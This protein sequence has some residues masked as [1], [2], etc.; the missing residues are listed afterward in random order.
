M[1]VLVSDCKITYDWSIRINSE[2]RWRYYFFHFFDFFSFSF[3]A[4]DYDDEN[5][6][7]STS[8]NADNLNP[9][10]WWLA[11]GIVELINVY[12]IVGTSNNNM[13]ILANNRH[14]KDIFF[15][16]SV[17]NSKLWKLIISRVNDYWLINI[18]A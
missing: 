10:V 14:D 8:S 11:M 16:K 6:K 18:D 9:K 5:Q 2:Q 1:L 15:N 4:N 13:V 7:G 12:F 3:D 17:N